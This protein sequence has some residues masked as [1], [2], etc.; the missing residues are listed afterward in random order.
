MGSRIYA[1]DE[2]TGLRPVNSWLHTITDRRFIFSRAL[3]NCPIP[4]CVRMHPVYPHTIGMLCPLPI[5][6]DYKL[7]H[8]FAYGTLTHCKLIYL[9]QIL[10]T[11]PGCKYSSTPSI[12]LIPSKNRDW[13]YIIYRSCNHLKLNM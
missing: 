4:L 3:I 10:D 5:Q 12:C 1:R 8:S 2:F 7:Q 6:G 11:Y 9:M 13:I